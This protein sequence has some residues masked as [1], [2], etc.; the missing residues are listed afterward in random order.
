MLSRRLNQFF[1][2]CH[3]GVC[4]HCTLY[5]RVAL[6]QALELP[7]D[8]F[9]MQEVHIQ[10]QEFQSGRNAAAAAAAIGARVDALDLRAQV[11]SLPWRFVVI[12]LTRRDY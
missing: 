2:K 3:S 11:Y 4:L 9:F 10:L 8:V 5:L 6:C 12:I 1:N 7:P